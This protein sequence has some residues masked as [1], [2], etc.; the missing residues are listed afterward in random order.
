[1]KRPAV[2]LTDDLRDKILELNAQGLTV[3]EIE[4][5]T[6]VGKSSVSRLL[7]N[8]TYKGRE[9]EDDL[10]LYRHFDGD[11]VLLY[12]GITDSPAERTRGHRGTARWW[13]QVATIT[14]QRGFTD[15]DQLLHAEQNAI[16]N[17]RPLHN[18]KFARRRPSPD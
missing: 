16:A 13:L 8:Y 10:V 1:M 4:A 12:V 2:Y 14:L 7:N 15:R 6:G 9:R 18:S 5:R 3:R 11:G 17:E